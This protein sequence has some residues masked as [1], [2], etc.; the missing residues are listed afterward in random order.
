LKAP[1]GIGIDKDG[2][3]Y[4]A[5]IG[6]DRVQVFDKDGNPLTMWGKKGSGTGEFG[7]L[8]GLI[9]DKQTGW[10]YVADTANNRVQVFKPAL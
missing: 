6:N 4:V 2:N 3:V 1:A 5:E 8:H 7:N 9:V 10:I